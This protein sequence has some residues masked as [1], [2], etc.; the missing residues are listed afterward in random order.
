MVLLVNLGGVWLCEGES[1]G[2]RFFFFMEGENKGGHK[3]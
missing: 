2:G 3:F 1:R